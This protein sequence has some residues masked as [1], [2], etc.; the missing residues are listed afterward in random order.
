[1]AP[2]AIVSSIVE[3][4]SRQLEGTF[5]EL[6]GTF[7]QLEGTFGQLEGTSIGV[8]IVSIEQD[9]I[10]RNQATADSGVEVAWAGSCLLIRAHVTI[11]TSPRDIRYEPSYRKARADDDGQHTAE[12]GGC[13]KSWSS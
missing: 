8:E 4:T 9:G 6:E 7:G 5:S 11:G 13:H 12:R 10:S 3:S 1:M 2:T